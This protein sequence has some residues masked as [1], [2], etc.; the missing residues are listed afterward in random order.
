MY[1]SVGVSQLLVAEP[2]GVQI[3]LVTKGSNRLSTVSSAVVSSVWSAD[4]HRVIPS[5]WLP[6]MRV[7]TFCPASQMAVPRV[8]TCLR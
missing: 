3:D 6:M 4:V 8:D 2:G 1:G 7:D 5:A